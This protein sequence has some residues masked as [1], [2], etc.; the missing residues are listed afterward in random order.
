MYP[1]SLLDDQP[2]IASFIRFTSN[3]LPDTTQAG[4]NA[5]AFSAKFT[6]V[7]FSFCSSSPLTGLNSLTGMTGQ[8]NATVQAEISGSLSP[9]SG[10]AAA[11]PA[12]AASGA[13]KPLTTASVTSSGSVVKASASA[14][15]TTASSKNNGA[16]HMAIPSVL[17]ATVVAALVFT[18]FF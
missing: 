11:T 4:A 15:G 1:F 2:C 14:T 13:S 7:V 5:E 6:Y 3:S 17:G 10:S 18:F 16:G 12:A 8:F 9:S